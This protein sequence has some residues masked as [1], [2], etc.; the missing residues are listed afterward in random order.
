[1]EGIH[2]YGDHDGELVFPEI[3]LSYLLDIGHLNPAH[4]KT[5]SDS[6]HYDN[7]ISRIQQRLANLG[8]YAGVIDRL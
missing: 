6:D 7:G 8:F 2:P 4:Q 3:G 1:V 5:K